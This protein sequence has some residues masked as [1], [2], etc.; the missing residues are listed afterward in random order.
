MSETGKRFFRKGTLREMWRETRWVYSHVR[1]YRRA[2]LWY[3][4]LGLSGTVLSLLVTLGSKELI[5]SIVF[6]GTKI[7]Y[8]GWRILFYGGTVV[9]LT[10]LN[11]LLTAVTGSYSAKVNLRV[12]NELRGEVFRVFLHTDWQSLQEYHSGDLLSRLNTDVT[13]VAN[14]VLGW[15]PTLVIQL[16]RF[17]AALC[18]ILL[19]DPTMAT[20]ALLVA[21]LSLLAARPYVR[22]IRTLG[23]DLR[24]VSADMMAFHE[25]ALQNAQSIQAFDLADNFLQRLYRVQGSYYDRAL[26]FNRVSV[27]NSAFLSV[28]SA[29]ISYLCLGWGAYRLWAWKVDFGTM[30]LFIQLAGYLSASLTVLIKLVPSAIDCT[31]SARRI[32]TIFELPREDYSQREQVQRLKQAGVPVELELREASL[33]YT[34]EERILEQVNLHIRAGETVAFVGPSGSGKTTLFRAFLGMLTPKK[35][36]AVIHMGGERLPASPAT[37]SLFAYVPQDNVMFSGTLADTLRLVRPD[38]TEEELYAALRLACAEDFVRKLPDGL[39]HRMRERGSTLSVGQNQRLALARAL[40]ADAPILLLDEV[41]SALDL[42]T[43]QRV[44]ENLSSLKGKT[45]ILTTHRP[46]VLSQCDHIYEVKDGHMRKIK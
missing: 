29:L 38:A 43:E 35:G 1:S 24:E 18:V 12:S 10:G 23:A 9:V 5:N 37:R 20:F 31:I 46:S 19:H 13:V 2:I 32:M 6:T 16:T 7:G 15:V 17:V 41:T 39:N 21:P 34:A 11:I 26:K 8:G 36:E 33:C 22:K 42:E 25:E 14:S 40:L 45:C 3:I 4:L 27:S 44:L 30:V 28:C